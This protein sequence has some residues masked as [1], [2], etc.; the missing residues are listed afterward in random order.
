M[1]SNQQEIDVNEIKIQS[2]QPQSPK[3]PI[4]KPSRF[5]LQPQR[6]EPQSLENLDASHVVR[7]NLTL[8]GQPSPRVRIPEMN[9]DSEIEVGRD[10]IRKSRNISN[11]RKEIAK[12]VQS[13][14]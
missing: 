1:N 3:K 12:K 6:I 8:S 11:K 14:P 13:G 7:K 2:I 5:S 9:D 4:L 10:K